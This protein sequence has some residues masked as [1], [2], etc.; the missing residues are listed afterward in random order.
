[1][2]LLLECFCGLPPS[3]FIWALSPS[4]LIFKSCGIFFP[5][6]FASTPSHECNPSLPTSFPHGCLVLLAEFPQ[7]LSLWILLSVR[8]S[9]LAL[10]PGVIRC[11]SCPPPR[12]HWEWSRGC[13]DHPAD[14][15]MLSWS[16]EPEFWAAFGLPPPSPGGTAGPRVCEGW[17]AGRSGAAANGREN[18]RRCRGRPPGGAARQG[19]QRRRLWAGWRRRSPLLL[20]RGAAGQ[21]GRASGSRPP[22]PGT[23]ALC[24]RSRASG[25]P[26][27]CSLLKQAGGAS[28][29]RW[30]QGRESRGGGRWVLERPPEGRKGIINPPSALAAAGQEAA[31]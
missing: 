16:V 6:P 10:V 1:M 18:A 9:S 23:A 3:F 13:P 24:C 22:P 25:A 29:G 4:F 27:C 21:H 28:P 26:A 5:P 17:Q 2:I 14:R 7:L 12:P 8:G 20:R 31:A 15:W 30:A 19:T 11:S